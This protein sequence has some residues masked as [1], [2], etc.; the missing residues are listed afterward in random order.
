MK[1]DDMI[2]KILGTRGKKKMKTKSKRE[3]H[4]TNDQAAHNLTRIACDQDLKLNDLKDI[5]NQHLSPMHSDQDDEVLRKESLKQLEILDQVLRQDSKSVCK[6]HEQKINNPAKIGRYLGIDCEMV[7]TGADGAN[8]VLA[9]VSI[10]NYHG[11]TVLDEYVKAKEKITDYR[12]WV[13]GI[14]PHHLKDASDFEDVQ[15]KIADL[16]KNRILVGHALKNDLNVLMLSHP[17]H[18]IRDTSKYAPFRKYAKGKHPALK[19]LAKELLGL[20]IQDGKHCS[21][22]D[23]KVAM[24]IFKKVKNDWEAKFKNK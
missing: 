10:V 7:G 16:L 22:E 4:S 12:S 13:S 19:T 11:I 20:E 2:D 15:K 24:L 9:R 17:S 21:V 3:I 14:Y 1:V 6:D 8:S 5:S 23:A 18:M